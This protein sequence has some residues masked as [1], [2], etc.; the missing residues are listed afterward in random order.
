MSSR[1]L[2]RSWQV[3]VSLF[4]LTATAAFGLL[5]DNRHALDVILR[6][7]AASVAGLAGLTALHQSGHV[8][9]FTWIVG[10]GALCFLA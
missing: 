7:S 4:V 5:D 3:T 2:P 6:V 9:G 1:T 8:A 10:V